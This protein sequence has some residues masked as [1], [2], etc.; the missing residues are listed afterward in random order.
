MKNI[1]F[2]LIFVISGCTNRTELGTE[3]NPISISLVPGQDAKVLEDNGK[4]MEKFLQEKTGFYFK[5]NVPVNYI[6]VVESI[7]SNRTDVALLNTYG[8]ILAN[9]K[10]GARVRLMGVNQGTFFYKGQIITKVGGPKTLKEIHG[11]KF[12]F[13]DPAS[14]SGY[15]M[16]AKLLSDQGV[17][18][19]EFIFAGK[20][21]SVVAMVYQGRVDAGATYYTAPENGE[22]R[23]ARIHLKTQ[24]PDVFEKVQV[25]AMTDPIPNDPIV[26]RKDFPAD[27]EE[28]I[29]QALK[30]FIQ[31]EEG[32]KVMKSLYHMSG[33][34]DST[35]KDY[36]DIRQTIRQLGKTANDMIQ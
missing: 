11:K 21:D 24:Y 4:I 20:H 26:F 2:I 34:K 3:K 27:L 33:L 36:E 6:A 16:A 35:D 28:K 31:T 25:I 23:D 18:P 12:A 8:Y 19:S 32:L 22:P 1:F 14:T 13:V 15:L 5:I 9:E 10:Y 17:K 30:D 7:G 29:I